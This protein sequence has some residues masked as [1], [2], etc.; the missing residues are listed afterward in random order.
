MY[1]KNECNCWEKKTVQNVNMLC[2]D[3]NIIIEQLKLIQYFFFIPQQNLLAS[4]QID[5]FVFIE[6]K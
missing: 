3:W 4:T 2:C 6:N 1:K 5:I